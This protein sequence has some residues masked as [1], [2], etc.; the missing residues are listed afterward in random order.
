MWGTMPDVLDR[1]CTYYQDQVAIVDGDRSLTYSELRDLSDK[2]G[3]A[4]LSLGL[5]K[6]DRVGLL[7]PNSLEFIPT[8]HGIWKSGAV[9]VQM[10]TRASAST[11][12]AN[13]NQTE[14]KASS[15]THP[16]TTWW[17]RCAVS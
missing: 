13:L 8:Q 7:L 17:L 16:S 10:P 14:A 2:V 5:E 12:V 3:S 11:Q 4:L 1:A 6:G 15:T 9:L